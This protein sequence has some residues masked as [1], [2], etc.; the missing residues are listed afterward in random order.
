MKKHK[1]LL[2]Y[3]GC[4]EIQRLIFFIER[5][6][7]VRNSSWMN[8]SKTLKGPHQI[9]KRLFCGKQFVDVLDW[10]KICGIQGVRAWKDFC[11]GG[12][13]LDTSG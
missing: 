5:L 10:R 3:I 9:I 12:L 6:L 2:K 1:D 11:D 13:Q 8:I 4:Q 7:N